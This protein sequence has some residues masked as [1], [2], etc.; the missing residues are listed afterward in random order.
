M[1]VNITVVG[2]VGAGGNVGAV[3]AAFLFRTSSLSLAAGVIGAGGFRDVGLHAGDVCPI[4][5]NG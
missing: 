1:R 3:L 4:F 5:G 2:I